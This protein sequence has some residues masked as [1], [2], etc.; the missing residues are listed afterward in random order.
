M[1]KSEKYLAY[2]KFMELELDEAKELMRKA[3]D[4]GLAKG[5]RCKHEIL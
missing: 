4:D 5:S 2:H 3:G 1:A